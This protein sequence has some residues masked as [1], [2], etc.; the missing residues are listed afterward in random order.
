MRARLEA[1]GAVQQYR[2]R[3]ALVAARLH[4]LNDAHVL[5]GHGQPAHGHA[6][7][8]GQRLPGGAQV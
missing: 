1:A 3:N 8:L 6:L 2:Q 4:R 5:E 7:A